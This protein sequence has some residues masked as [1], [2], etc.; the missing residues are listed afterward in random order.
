MYAYFSPI[1]L[2][3]T[4]L[5]KKAENVS[6]PARTPLIT[7]NLGKNKNQGGGGKIM[8]LKFNICTPEKVINTLLAIFTTV[9]E[10]SIILGSEELYVYNIHYFWHYDYFL[11]IYNLLFSITTPF[12]KTYRNSWSFCSKRS[13][14]RNQLFWCAFKKGIC[15]Q[16]PTLYSRDCWRCSWKQSTFSI[17]ISLKLV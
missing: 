7:I 4:K 3:Y 11:M 8:N 9:I 12:L 10:T 5:Q 14:R 15:S 13:H 6:P 1:D 2:T 16:N 17:R